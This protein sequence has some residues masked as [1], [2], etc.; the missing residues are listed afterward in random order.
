[1]M[2]NNF[3]KNCLVVGIIFLFIGISIAPSII[4]V[5]GVNYHLVNVKTKGA[6]DETSSVDND[7]EYWALL[8]YMGIYAGHPDQNFPPEALEFFEKFHNKLLISEHWKEENIKVIKGRRATLLN[9]IRGFRWLDRKEDKNDFSLVYIS[10]HGGQLPKDKFPWDE[11]DGCDE[12]LATYLSFMFPRIN[13][14]DDLLN[15][16]LSLLNSKGVCVVVDSC[17]AGGF[18]DTPYFKNL[19]KNN[20]MNV[21]ERVHGFAEELSES[22]RIVLMASREDELAW[23]GFTMYLTEGLTGYAD[24]NEDDLVSAEEAFYYA[25]ERYDWEEYNIHATIYDDYPGELQL[26]VVELPPSVPETPIG[27]D[28]GDTN[29]TYYY[30]TVSTDPAGDKISYGWDWDSDFVVDEWTDFVDSNTTVNTS[31]SWT[32][33]GIYNIRVRVKDEHGLLSDWSDYIDVIMCDDNIPDQWQRETDYGCWINNIWIAQSFV[34]SLNT[35][36]KVEIALKSYGQGDP[37]PLHLYIRD[38]LTGNNLTE[39][40]LAIPELGDDKWAWYTFNFEDIDV[41]PGEPYYIICK[42]RSD[43]TF[44][45]RWKKGNPYTH[46][47]VFTSNDGK[48]WRAIYPPDDAD[49]C[50]VTWSKK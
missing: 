20:K 38:N 26:T 35:L 42:G 46:G 2:K 27:Q 12:V 11:K 19:W 14:R 5:E 32:I 41:I 17:H 24:T 28:F 37:K 47:E 16:L 30:Y 13:I 1:M 7:T 25:K 40:S 31:H 39:S 49:S 33:E 36:S 9:I 18:N 21:N 10:T 6:S 48:E 43:W 4:G 34:P 44:N 22:G 29:T 23:G 45:W 3:V 15:L 8:I 50:F